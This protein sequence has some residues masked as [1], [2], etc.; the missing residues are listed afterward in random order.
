MYNLPDAHG[1]GP[2]M[3][4]V[5]HARPGT[6]LIGALLKAGAD[7]HQ[8]NRYGKTPMALA[9]ETDRVQQMSTEGGASP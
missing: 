8:K 7:P 9:E 6:G 3:V 2:L 5:Q 4:A 1:N